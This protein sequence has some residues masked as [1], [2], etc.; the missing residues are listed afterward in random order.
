MHTP[1][2]ILPQHLRLPRR[3]ALQAGAV[4]LLGLGMN[5]VAGLRALAAP[6]DR[7]AAAPK[8]KAVIYIFLSGGLAQHDS[9]D[10]KP[11]APEGIR[12]EFNPIATR[13]PGIQI[14]EHLP[15]LAERSERWSLV[16]LDAS[17]RAGTFGWPPVDAHRPEQAADR[18]Q[19]VEADAHR[20]AVDG[21]RGQRRLPAAQ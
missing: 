11:D 15:M 5:H 1:Q 16:P 19:W 6:A 3:Q 4:G 21:G 20:L 17:R 13:T 18:F 2:P 10:M 7:A 8:A 14:C 12:G 9:F